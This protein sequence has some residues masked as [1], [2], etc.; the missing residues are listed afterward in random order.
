MLWYQIRTL[1][2]KNILVLRKKFLFSS[3]LVVVLELFYFSF[4][5]PSAAETLYSLHPN[6]I[7]R[8]YPIVCL[9][10]KGETSLKVVATQRPLEKS[11]KVHE[12][13]IWHGVLHQQKPT[14]SEMGVRLV[15]LPNSEW[16][17]SDVKCSFLHCNAFSQ[18]T[19]CDSEIDGSWW[20]T[21]IVVQQGRQQRL[22][23]VGCFHMF[24]ICAD[25]SMP[26]SAYCLVLSNL[27]NKVWH[28]LMLWCL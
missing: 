7:M 4:S 15:N 20:V 8:Q 11:C 23:L 22:R 27:A 1:Q 16:Q 28:F 19:S 3:K 6:C 12:V 26:A 17:S 10:C 5:A 13:Y 9:S 18:F 2:R 24:A 14:K 25:V 21:L